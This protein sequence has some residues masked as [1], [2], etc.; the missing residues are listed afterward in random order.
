MMAT[1]VTRPLPERGGETEGEVR[2]CGGSPL[3]FD[4]VE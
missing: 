4:G 1:D 3:S 2:G